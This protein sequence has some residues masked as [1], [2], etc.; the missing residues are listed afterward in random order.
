KRHEAGGL[1]AENQVEGHLPVQ[2]LIDADTLKRAGKSRLEI[3]VLKAIG[4][5]HRRGLSGLSDCRNGHQESREHPKQQTTRGRT[6]TSQHYSWFS[7]TIWFPRPLSE[8]VL[9]LLCAA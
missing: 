4:R 9:T 1:I 2:A 3:A 8:G 5:L 7:P 6:F